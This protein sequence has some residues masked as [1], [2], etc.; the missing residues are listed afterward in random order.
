LKMQIFLWE[1]SDGGT[2][3]RGKIFQIDQKEIKKIR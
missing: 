1:G 3:W 2:E